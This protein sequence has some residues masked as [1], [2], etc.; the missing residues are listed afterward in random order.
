MQYKALY[1]RN[2]TIP[3]VSGHGGPR[4][5]VCGPDQDAQRTFQATEGSDLTQ[6]EMPLI[7][8]TSLAIILGPGRRHQPVTPTP[9]FT[10]PQHLSKIAAKHSKHGCL[11]IMPIL[12][13]TRSLATLS[14][15][16]EPIR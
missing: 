13:Q 16:T 12:C 2:Y 14:A 15:Q 4:R 10:P 5:G 9:K 8:L 11:S 1:D 3:R 7:T 6:I